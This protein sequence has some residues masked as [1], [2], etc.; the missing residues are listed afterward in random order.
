MNV[1]PILEAAAFARPGF[2]LASFKQAGLPVYLLTVRV[3]VLEKKPLSPIE[4]GCLRAVEAGLASPE[5]IC[6]FL[7]LATNVMTGA[8]AGLNAKECINY[9]RAS[10]EGRQE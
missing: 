2:T 7:G 5:D 9:S 10:S 3:L 8:L 4:E 6:S 1:E